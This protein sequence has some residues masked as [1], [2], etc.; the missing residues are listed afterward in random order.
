MVANATGSHG[1][2]FKVS[3]G[4]AIGPS[5][6]RPSPSP[7]SCSRARARARARARKE[8]EAAILNGYFFKGGPRPLGLMF[9][10]LKM[11]VRGPMGVAISFTRCQPKSS[12]RDSSVVYMALDC[13]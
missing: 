9:V 7:I 4:I 6:P 2:F 13:M 12:G 3:E 11:T 8:Q 10:L 1:P 5:R